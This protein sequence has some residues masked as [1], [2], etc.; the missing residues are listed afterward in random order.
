[1]IGGMVALLQAQREERDVR[2]VVNEFGKNY[3]FP[4]LLLV[5]ASRGFEAAMLHSQSIGAADRSPQRIMEWLVVIVWIV[6]IGPRGLMRS[7]HASGGQRFERNKRRLVV[8][9]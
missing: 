2:K 3:D 4:V 5:V 1:M 6:V 7:L 8:P 9:Y